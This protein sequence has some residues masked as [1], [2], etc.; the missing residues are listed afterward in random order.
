MATNKILDSIGFLEGLGAIIIVFAVIGTIGK[1]FHDIAENRIEIRKISKL[2]ER[3]STLE[4]ESIKFKYEMES[5][6]RTLAIKHRDIADRFTQIENFL[7]AKSTYQK[8]ES[9]NSDGNFDFFN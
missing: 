3:I 1:I 7:A 9:S 6:S 5:L 8:R 2:Q 4:A